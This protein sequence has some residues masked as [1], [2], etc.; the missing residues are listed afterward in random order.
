VK[1]GW[2]RVNLNYFISPAAADYIADAVQL[3]A[4][5]GYR[6]LPDYSFDPRTGLWW[7][8]GRDRQTL[9]RL[10]DLCYGPAGEMRYPRRHAQAGEDVFPG[11]LRRARDLLAARPA[12]LDDGPTGLGQGFEALRWFP[13]PAACLRYQPAS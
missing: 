9:L 12:A 4:A 7:H 2:T 8:A 5:E 6:L 1:P 13:L 3:V 11:Y 10:T